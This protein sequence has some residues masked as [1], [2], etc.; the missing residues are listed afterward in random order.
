M[1]W[2]SVADTSVAGSEAVVV[3]HL[4]VGLPRGILASA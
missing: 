2:A 4:M 1:W 3:Q